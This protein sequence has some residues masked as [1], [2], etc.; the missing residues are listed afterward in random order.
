M[1]KINLKTNDTN[2]QIEI[3]GQPNYD[4]MSE[5]DKSVFAGK[6][7]KVVFEIFEKYLKRKK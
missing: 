2:M 3:D 7:E 6:F 5:V 1:E 4:N